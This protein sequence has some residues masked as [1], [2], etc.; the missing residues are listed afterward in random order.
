[1]DGFEASFV[2][3]H[4]RALSTICDRVGLNYFGIDC[5]ELDNGMLVVF[6]ADNALIVH[7]MDPPDIYPYKPP[8]MQ[9]IFSAFETMLYAH[10]AD[11]KESTLL[12][13]I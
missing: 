6:E 8:H 2:T 7:Y 3:R 13:A 1:M 9:R 10:A 4:Q 11:S 5:P 12:H